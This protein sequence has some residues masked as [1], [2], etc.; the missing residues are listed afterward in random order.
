M[1]FATV[2]GRWRGYELS[3]LDA[4]EILGVTERTFRRWCRRYEEEG[5]DGLLDRRLGKPS[6]KRVRRRCQRQVCGLSCSR[7]LPVWRVSWAGLFR[8]SVGE[9]GSKRWSRDWNDRR[10]PERRARGFAGRFRGKDNPD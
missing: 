1:K 4:A 6:A 10:R 2:R 7:R 8:A 3:Q 9:P 5:A